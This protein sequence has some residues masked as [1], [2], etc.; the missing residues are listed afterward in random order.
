MAARRPSSV[1]FPL[2]L[3]VPPFGC[4]PQKFLHL[5]SR[6]TCHS[7]GAGARERVEGLGIEPMAGIRIRDEEVNDGLA[8]AHPSLDVRCIGAEDFV[9][10]LVV[11]VDEWQD[12]PAGFPRRGRVRAYA[13]QRDNRTGDVVDELC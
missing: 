2:P 4:D 3:G 12:I 7:G 9:N 1:E 13:A 11:G 5:A 8:T 6:G 10:R